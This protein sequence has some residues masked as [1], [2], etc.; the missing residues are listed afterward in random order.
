MVTGR[1]SLAPIE[2]GRPRRLTVLGAT[3]S[4]GT[5]T[6]DLVARDPERFE[7]AALVAHSDLDRLVSA[8]LKVR[9]ARAVLA[10]PT[11]REALRDA[12]A[13]TGIE[14]DAGAE[15]VIEAATMPADMVVA[16]IVGAAS[17]E[18]TFAAIRAGRAVALASKECLVAAGTLFMAEARRCGALV[19]PLDS[20]HNAIFQAFGGESA[21]AVERI[22]LTAS[23]GPF[24]AA[25]VEA[26]REATP[27][28]ALKHPNWSMGARITIDSATMMNKGLEVIEA[29]HLFGLPG[30]R[31][32]VLVH[33]QSIVHG[34]VVHRDGSVVAGLAAPDMRTPIA[35]CIHWPDRGAAPTA[36]LD[37]ARLGGLTFEAP[38]L[39]RFPALRLAYAA[40]AAG[41]GAGCVYNAAD[42][43][44]VAA[45]L[46]RRIGFLDIAAIVEATLDEADRLGLAREPADLAAVSVL[47]GEARRIAEARVRGLAAMG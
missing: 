25:S 39:E 24:R 36:R 16:A 27:E 41:G 2:P 4:I 18:P 34:M 19:L 43:V 38:D 3:G 13:G 46:Q 21:V 8:A 28:Q 20:E 32:D 11:R 29:H 9:P 30:E 37:L 33:P 35:H 7:V 1:G 14:T 6:L 15:A 17:L 12:L 40:L 10:D 47:D 23:G 44:A 31:I 5:S 22:V 42:E 45:F 26:M